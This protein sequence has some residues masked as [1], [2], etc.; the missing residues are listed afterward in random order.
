ME[1]RRAIG[2]LAEP[3]GTLFTGRCGRGKSRA[4]RSECALK[5]FLGVDGGA[6]KTMAVVG[7]AHG[8]ILSAGLAGPTNY[9]NVGL[10]KAMSNLDKSIT[11]AL[12]A[13]NLTIDDISSAVFGIA[14]AD[15]PIDFDVLNG[16]L[17]RLYPDLAY[18][19]TNDTW[20]AF[21][22]GSEK[23]HGVVVI[24]GTGANFAARSPDGRKV[25]GRGMGY[26]WGSEGGAISLI[27]S[28][29]HRAFR[30]HDGTG[31]KTLLEE[32]VLS[33]MGF[34]SYDDL[35]FYLYQVNAQRP[36]LLT[37]ASPVVPAIFQLAFQ[38]DQVAQDILVYTGNA[39][40]EIAGRLG[41]R[42]GLGS[43]PTDIVMAG[44]TYKGNE[45]PMVTAFRPLV[46]VLCLLGHSDF[47]NGTCGGAYSWPLSMLG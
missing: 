1:Q 10:E 47:Q 34:S 15:Y 44:S 2:S 35:S 14:G 33:L 8:N 24:S 26:E 6:T 22:S 20:V 28:A 43:V 31:R 29:L 45:P 3:Q 7:D 11:Q 12:S 23:D 9:Q 37:R 17:A 41:A 39:M 30:S 19:L 38:G 40:G 42:M 21:R 27:R 5:C 13:A 36:E 18:E 4:G 16:A 46:S 25:T 32:A